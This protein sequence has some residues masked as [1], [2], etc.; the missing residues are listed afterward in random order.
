MS[1]F[2]LI[3]LNISVN[4]EVLA[5]NLDLFRESV[6]SQIALINRQPETDEEYDQ[7]DNDV[8]VL[9]NAETVVAEAKKAAIEGASSL[10]VLFAALDDAVSEISTARLSLEKSIKERRERRKKE[11]FDKSAE[12]I[13]CPVRH[14]AR[15][16]VQLENSMKG[17]RSFDSMK[18]ALGQ[19]VALINRNISDTRKVIDSFI[20]TNGTTLVYDR[21]DLEV[22]MHDA[23]DAELRRRLES[24]KAELERKR[25]QEETDKAKAELRRKQEQERQ[26]LALNNAPPRTTASTP[27][28][29]KEDSAE[30]APVE[31][32][33][34][35]EEWAKFTASVRECFGQLKPA[36]DALVHE[37]NKAKA[38]AF[39][40]AVGV[41][42]K[43][44]NT[45]TAQ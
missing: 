42:W 43:K 3:P 13:D 30:G 41:A 15:Y 1:A 4:G 45:E 24:H 40:E 22:K 34:A 18:K 11:L 32:I 17:K 14:R 25:L 12:A 35:P 23:V 28:G 9:K 20:A 2:T 37:E 8:K 33:S 5:S 10:N 19:A 36:K 29:R 7:A 6:K 31:I 44:I 38:A 27:I 26:Q 16:T 39:S 21:E